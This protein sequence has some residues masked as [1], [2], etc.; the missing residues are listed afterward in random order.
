M[1]CKR[2]AS[3]YYTLEKRDI[4]N[5]TIADESNI[6]T[7]ICTCPQRGALRSVNFSKKTKYY[8]D[9]KLVRRSIDCQ[10]I[11]PC[12]ERKLEPENIQARDVQLVQPMADFRRPFY[13]KVCVAAFLL[14]AEALAVEIGQSLGFPSY[15]I[16]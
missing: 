6:C 13:Q 9:P 15:F 12:I 16:Q 8:I 4:I 11:R 7:N 14:E 2:H 10:L 3:D 5:I 1:L